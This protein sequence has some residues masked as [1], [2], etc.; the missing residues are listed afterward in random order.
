MSHGLAFRLKENFFAL[1]SPNCMMAL[2]LITE[3]DPFLSEHIKI[4]AK[5]GSGTTSYL[6]SLACEEFIDIVENRVVW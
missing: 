3:F 4:H 5:K 2:E 1:H 6:L